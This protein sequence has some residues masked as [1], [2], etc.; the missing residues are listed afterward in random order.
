MRALCGSELHRPQHKQRGGLPP[1]ELHVDQKEHADKLLADGHEDLNFLLMVQR[2]SRHGAVAPREND[3]Q[4]GH[5]QGPL[6]D[7]AGDHV[8]QRHGRAVHGAG[9]VKRRRQLGKLRDER[10]HPLDENEA[11]HADQSRDGEQAS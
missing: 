4:H 8:H 3:R 5:Q 1:G 2:N 10:R 11:G 7:V 6:V 9:P